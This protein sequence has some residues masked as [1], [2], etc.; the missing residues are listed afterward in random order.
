MMHEQ[1]RSGHGHEQRCEHERQQRAALAE[2]LRMR[3][4]AELA[5]WAQL[6]TFGA[7]QPASHSLAPIDEAVRGGTPLQRLV[8]PAND[9]PSSVVNEH[10]T[11]CSRRRD[12]TWYSFS[13]GSNTKRL[14]KEYG[15]S[16]GSAIAPLDADGFT[17]S[18]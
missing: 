4:C 7:P 18:S 11:C 10:N 1:H 12:D 2:E 9:H 5:V 13:V 8:L 15:Q 17:L 3:G 16:T 14:K 6:A